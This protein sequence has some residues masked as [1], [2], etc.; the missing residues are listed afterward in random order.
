MMDT[1]Q[2]REGAFTCAW[3]TLG[4]SQLSFLFSLLFASEADLPLIIALAV[5]MSASAA[6]AGMW[7]SLQFKW[8]QMQYPA[9]AIMFE[10][11]LITGATPLASIM[12]TL[13]LALVVE[14]A[15]VP[16][17]LAASMCLLYFL[18]G[19]PLT[20]SFSN[21]KAGPPSIG[22]GRASKAMVVGPT[23]VSAAQIASAV[24][25]RFD[26]FL[27]ALLTISVP[28]LA[29]MAIH[30]TVMFRHA[31]HIYSILLLAS[32]AAVF[33]C[34]IPRGLW[35]LPGPPRLVLLLRL[36]LLASALLAFM[37]GFEGRVVFYA[38]RQYIKLHPPWDWLA[39]TAALLGLG[40]AAL[41]HQG[42]LFGQAVDVALAGTIMLLCTTAGSLAAGVPLAWLP[43][44]LVVSTMKSQRSDEERRLPRV[45]R[46]LS[47]S[48]S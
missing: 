34:L 21:S 7:V 26:A 31:V 1:L 3:I 22:G 17:F 45:R 44:P 36:F 24:Q 23:G 27:L 29:Y 13:A 6:L 20:S 41:A 37:V 2:Y 15:D 10:R 12:H 42:G 33:I 14:A 46:S 48:L 28:S 25:S 16:F 30:W 35:W 38:F 43:A 18:L 47:K 4:A 39:V 32:S 5:S 19:R 11:I 8:M 9:V 40:A